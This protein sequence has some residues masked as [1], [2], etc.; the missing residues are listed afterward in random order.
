MDLRGHKVEDLASGLVG[1]VTGMSEHISRQRQA[2]VQPP[3]KDG[4]KPK[5]V[6]IDVETLKDLGATELQAKF[7]DTTSLNLGDKLRHEVAGVEGTAQDKIVYLN[8]CVHFG[9][10][11]K[12]N[13]DGDVKTYYFDHKELTVLTPAKAQPVAASCGGPDRQHWG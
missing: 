12:A 11:A 13:R 7:P 6:W 1:V 8:G 4:D 10:T 9:V 3:A 5:G 2:L